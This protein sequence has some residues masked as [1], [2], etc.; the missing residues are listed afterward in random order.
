MADDFVIVD[1]KL[2][3]YTGNAKVVNIP[4]GVTTINFRAFYNQ[5]IEQVTLPSTLKIIG[6]EAFAFNK[7]TSIEFKSPVEIDAGAFKFNEIKEVIGPV[8]SCNA[9]AFDENPID[10]QKIVVIDGIL[11]KYNSYDYVVVIPEGVTII[12]HGAFLNK[13][14]KQVTFPSTLK[15]IESKAF[16][17]NQLTRV[18]FKSPV[19]IEDSAFE[20]NEIKE[21]TGPVVSCSPN[22][23]DFNPIMKQY[24]I[25]IDSILLEY[26]ALDSIV[27]I[28]EGVKKIAQN[29]FS[30]K[31][32]KSVTFPSSLEVIEEFAF[33]HN[34]L[35]ELTF[36]SPVVIKSNAFSYNL[37]TK[38]SGQVKELHANAFNHK[39]P[40]IEFEDG[41]EL[42][43][44]TNANHII[45]PS[46]TKKIKGSFSN[47]TI[48]NPSLTL[49]DNIAKDKP[50]I[51]NLVI[52]TTLY[53]SKIDKRV[54]ELGSW[55]TYKYYDKCLRDNIELNEVIIEIES[56]LNNTHTSKSEVIKYI[57]SLIK[58][59]EEFIN[60]NKP[61]YK[62]EFNLS[63]TSIFSK[64]FE[65]RSKLIELK[66]YLLAEIKRGEII[67]EIKRVIDDLNNSNANDSITS[68][69]NYLNL[70]NDELF[71]T[72]LIEELESIIENLR[73][74][75]HNVDDDVLS[76]ALAK[77]TLIAEH[78]L[79]IMK[80]YY[81]LLDLFNK[82]ID[83]MK[84]IVANTPFKS[85]LEAYIIKSEGLRKN[86]ENILALSKDN[87][88][89]LSVLKENINTVL[90]S[91]L[92][93]YNQLKYFI[94][95]FDETENYPRFS[96]SVITSNYILSINQVLE[97]IYT[98]IELGNVD[99]ETK[100]LIESE[101]ATIMKKW[102]N[103]MIESDFVY[104]ENSSFD[105]MQ[106]ND[107]YKFELEILKELYLIVF[108]L[109]TYLNNLSFYET[110]RK[111]S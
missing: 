59:Y 40:N 94:N 103:K 77:Y 101:I 90:N 16:K 70:S 72:S 33:A 8:V 30:C 87:N 54:K 100:K 48:I 98:L 47:I 73:H 19:E 4:E 51:K 79:D 42:I 80:P 108:N 56:I 21:V 22:A 29:A 62:E 36:K 82:Q 25:I 38:I 96:D 24:F 50:D 68:I 99:E 5:Q 28:P 89:D 52:E 45:L 6:S 71:K 76:K 78:K 37:I 20:M 39:L 46:T 3:K 12:K 32:L 17:N 88:L 43:E 9:T 23:F 106:V 61:T 111:Y 110:L 65:L 91:F 102:Q 1:G 58:D 107:N 66:N 26:N 67:S 74:N 27:E 83:I 34:L 18:E 35:K 63:K 53:N 55:A 44:T 31:N 84:I 57:L 13:Q 14:I 104:Q 86:L 109:E 93:K 75:K 97:V 2:I 92:D 64:T 11:I 69:I 105:N 81:E 49:L 60:E 41:L 95:L 15:K 7:L 10:K 85:S